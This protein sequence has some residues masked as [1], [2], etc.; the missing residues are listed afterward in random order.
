MSTIKTAQTQHPVLDL[1]KKRWS[2]RSFFQEEMEQADLDTI[3]EAASWAASANNEQ[4]WQYVYAHRGTEGYE[5]LKSCL[6][7]MN[8]TWAKDSAVLIA[9]IARKTFASGDD[10]KWALHDLGMANAQLLL[11]ALSMNIYGHPMAGFNREKLSELLSLNEQQEAVCMIALGFLDIP[12]KL[13]EPLRSRETQVRQRKPLTAFT[14]L[15]S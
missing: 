12:D 8:Q 6:N 1:I 4:P 11:Q 2:P 14:T 3:L 15:L 13:D 10:N 5:T 9:A 7:P